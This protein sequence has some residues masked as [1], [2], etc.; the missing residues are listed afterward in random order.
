MQHP[1]SGGQL[2]PFLPRGVKDLSKDEFVDLKPQRIVEIDPAR[3]AIWE[4]LCTCGRTR[5]VPAKNL[6]SY[7][8]TCCNTCRRERRNEQLKLAA[9]N[10][11]LRCGDSN[12]VFRRHSE[13]FLETMTPEQRAVYDDYIKRRQR[14]GIKITDAI[15]AGA[16]EVAMLEQAAA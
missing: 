4:C 2:I 11:R 7:R 6:T 9:K 16:V 8:V 12:S 13:H 15:R 10:M 1:R 14:L 5:N 3:G